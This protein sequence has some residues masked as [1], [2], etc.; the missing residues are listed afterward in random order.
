[1]NDNKEKMLTSKEKREILKRT[2][3]AVNA[4]DNGFV[5]RD[6]LQYCIDLSGEFISIYLSA[7]VIDGIAQSKPFADL[8]KYAAIV[9]GIQAVLSVIK[10]LLLRRKDSHVFRRN[11]N[12]KKSL[13]YKVMTMDFIHL[14]STD[15]RNKYSKASRQP[16]N[17]N[18]GIGAFCNYFK[19]TIGGI[20]LTVTGFILI[21]P[22]AFRPCEAAA[23][24]AGFI[25]S[26]WGFAAVAVITAML[27]Y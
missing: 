18:S 7:L 22:M 20:F 17:Y 14:E 2:L 11:T 15:M 27:G 16:E 23:G 26:V 25:Q 4:A 1:M 9:V 21:I 12:L 24:F 10:R 3:K 13:W 6:T 19:N 8:L 5:L